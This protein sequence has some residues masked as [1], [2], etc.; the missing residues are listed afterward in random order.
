MDP[1]SEAP[2]E[3]EGVELVVEVLY[4]AAKEAWNQ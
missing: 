4:L 1:A 2:I 3:P